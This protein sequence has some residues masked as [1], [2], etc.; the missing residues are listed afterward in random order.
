M[1]VP[2]Y[3]LNW[4][5]DDAEYAKYVHLPQLSTR[6]LDPSHSL[7]MLYTHTL[8]VLKETTSEMESEMIRFQMI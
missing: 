3:F 7:Q 8:H 6:I 4:Q 5:I 2:L 1:K